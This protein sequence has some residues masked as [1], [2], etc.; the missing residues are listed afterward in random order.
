LLSREAHRSALDLR[1]RHV[2]R[3]SVINIT[4]V[5]F[6]RALELHPIRIHWVEANVNHLTVGFSATP[7]QLGNISD[8]FRTVNSLIARELNKKWN[9]EGHI[10]SS[11]FRTIIC[12]DDQAAERQL[13]YCVTNPV[14]DSLV[15]TVRESPLFTCYRALANG[16]PMR[17]WR[18]DWNAFHL[19]GGFRKKSHCPKEHLEW[20]TLELAPLPHQADWPAHKRQA[21]LRTAVR[22]FEEANAAVLLSDGRRASD[23]AALHLVDPRD[24]PAD[25]KESGPQPLCHASSRE[26]RLEYAR[27]WREIASAHREASIEYRQGD[28]EREFPEGTF[29]PPLTT[30]YGSRPRL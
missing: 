22:D 2:P 30:P 9:H 28:W 25:P 6:A 20:L 15:S 4:G 8:F 10:W 16:K 14:K 26:A 12:T 5:A 29:R 13:L 23:A 3:P 27:G 7:D 1:N 24:R 19:S 21:W 18:I 11:P 17:F